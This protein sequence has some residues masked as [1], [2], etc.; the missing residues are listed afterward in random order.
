MPSTPFSE[1]SHLELLFLLDYFHE[2]NRQ[3]NKPIDVQ[4]RALASCEE[5]LRDSAETEELIKQYEQSKKL[6]SEA[7]LKSTQQTINPEG[8]ENDDWEWDVKT[9]EVRLLEKRNRTGAGEYSGKS[10]EHMPKVGASA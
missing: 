3:P 8:E 9:K 4:L 10:E 6:N 5:L 2:Y 7:L 1:K